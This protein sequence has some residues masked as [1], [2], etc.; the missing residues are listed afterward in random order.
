MRNSR[1]V[2]LTGAGISA[3]SGVRTF[4]D[5][6][7]LWEN[8]RIEDVATPEAWS[9]DPSLVW[10]FYQARRKQLLLVEPNPA[11]KALARLESDVES[12]TLITQNVDD[13]HERG[14]STSPIHMHGSLR[15]LRCEETSKAEVRMANSDLGEDF[16]YCNCCVEASRMR[17]DIVWFG[18]VP[19]RMEEIYKSVEECDIF[20]V[21]GSSGHV[22]PAAGLVNFANSSGARSILVNYDLPINGHDFD[23]VHIGRAGDLLP[24]IVSSWL[25]D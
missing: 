10:K 17:P 8:H 4:R 3:E 20:I 24:G 6:D 15:T 23:E 13:L 1:I 16:V 25:G 7:G 9:R 12:F 18:E 11:H 19:M 2:V 22:Y 21:I 5:N 14:G